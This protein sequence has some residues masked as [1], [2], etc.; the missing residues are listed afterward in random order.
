M[1]KMKDSNNFNGMNKDGETA[2]MFGIFI[3]KTE[4]NF[5]FISPNLFIS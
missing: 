2:L 5:K 4:N 3:F 1:N